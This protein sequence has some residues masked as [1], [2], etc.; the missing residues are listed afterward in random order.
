[1]SMQSTLGGRGA[2]FSLAA[3]LG[4]GAAI[5]GFIG[6]SP[7]TA[8]ETA[9]ASASFAFSDEAGPYDGTVAIPK[10][11]PTLGTLT[12]ATISTS[13]RVGYDVCVWNGSPEAIS[14]TTGTVTGSVDFTIP[15]GAAGRSISEHA[16]GEFTV[17]LGPSAGDDVCAGWRPSHGPIDE[18]AGDA[19]RFTGEVGPVTED[20]APIT[21]PAALAAFTADAGSTEILIPWNVTS[22]ATAG[23]NSEGTHSVWTTAAGSVTIVYT[24]DSAGGPTTSPPPATPVDTPVDTPVTPAAEAVAAA[25]DLARTGAS[26]VGALTAVGAIAVAAGAGALVVARRRTRAQDAT[27]PR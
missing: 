3:A 18:T 26:G 17:A 9:P 6:I 11:D 4:M 5:V 1:M 25:N 19:K 27:P 12:S 21:D 13:V 8:A 24:Y 20:L 22:A 10:F 14:D 23:Q 15:D 16:D 2:R 7:A